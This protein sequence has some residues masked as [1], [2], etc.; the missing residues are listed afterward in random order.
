MRKTHPSRTGHRPVRFATKR[1]DRLVRL[2]AAV[3]LIRL[4][5]LE[6]ADPLFD[7]LPGF[8]F[9][10]AIAFL[11]LASQQLDIAF[12]LLYVVV[13]EFAPL[14]ACASTQLLPIALN[15]VP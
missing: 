8:R 9:R 13:R 3:R 14:V 5:R 4:V 12:D 2:C 11:N 15:S 1:T 6:L 10:H 7:L